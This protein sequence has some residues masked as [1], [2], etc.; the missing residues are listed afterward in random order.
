[1]LTSYHLVCIGVE[2]AVWDLSLLGWIDGGTCPHINKVS[3]HTIGPACTALLDPWTRTHLKKAW[4]EVAVSQISLPAIPDN[5]VYFDISYEPLTAVRTTRYQLDVMPPNPGTLDMALPLDAQG[6]HLSLTLMSTV[7][8][9]VRAVHTDPSLA[10]GQ[11]CSRWEAD[12]CSGLFAYAPRTSP[13]TSL[14][15][16]MGGPVEESLLTRHAHL[17]RVKVPLAFCALSERMICF[18]RGGGDMKVVDFLP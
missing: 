11:V 14:P 1:M 10:H 8:F 6:P 3:S 12:M 17:N 18:W 15:I 9:P 7:C 16:T 2:I 5:R 4:P 13:S